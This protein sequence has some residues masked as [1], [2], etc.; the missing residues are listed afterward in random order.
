MPEE[1]IYQAAKEVLRERN[2][3][4]GIADEGGF[5]PEFSTNEEILPILSEAIER[6][7][8][9]GGKEAAISLDIAASGLFDQGTVSGAKAASSALNS[10][11]IY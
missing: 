2:K 4:F 3:Y 7:G 10:S 9:V 5:W 11:Q 6:A 8:Y 1:P